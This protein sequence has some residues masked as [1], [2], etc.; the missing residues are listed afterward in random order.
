L[1]ISRKVFIR[2]KAKSL[3]IMNTH[4]AIMDVV[5]LLKNRIVSEEI[6]SLYNIWEGRYTDIEY[7][8]KARF[9]LSQHYPITSWKNPEHENMLIDLAIDSH[10]PR[11][12]PEFLEGGWTKENFI[13]D[14]LRDLFIYYKVW[15]N[16][17]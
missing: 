7:D 2:N 3:Y 11:W 10:A 17:K 5:D 15:E 4:I 13:L 8:F 14:G 6:N 12:K 9:N 1:L 16:I